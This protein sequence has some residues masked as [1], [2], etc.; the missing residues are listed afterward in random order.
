MAERLL[1]VTLNGDPL[2]DLGSEH[3]GGQCKYVLELSKNLIL[4]G[5]NIHV[6]TLAGAP[7]PE[8]EAVTDGLMISRLWRPGR[9]PY[10][11]DITEAEIELVGGALAERV[12]AGL[13]D[14][15]AVLAC[16]WISGLAAFPVARDHGWP[17][18]ITFCSLG[19]F[20]MAAD[21]SP[22]VVRRAEIEA[23]LG[24][25]CQAVIATNSHEAAA[26]NQ[27]YGIDRRKIHLIPRGVD[28]AVF[29]P[30]AQC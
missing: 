25:R 8:E 16:Y 28:L 23:E 1:I 2:A 21:P 5:W 24:R 18:V 20:K 15:R 12:R 30:Q 3:A 10:A 11:Y 14:F 26:L 27:V 22:S 19:Y 4:R 7:R 13:G 17:L 29:S 9:R 6:I